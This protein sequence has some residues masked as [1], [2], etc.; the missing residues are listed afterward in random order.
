M[1]DYLFEQARGTL[2][3]DDITR[4]TVAVNITNS[5]NQYLDKCRELTSAHILACAQEAWRMNVDRAVRVER[6]LAYCKRGDDR[7]VVGAFAI[8]KAPDEKG[9]QMG[10]WQPSADGDRMIFLGYPATDRRDYEMKLLPPLPHG[11]R[12]PVKYYD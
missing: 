12:N 10:R 2:K 11:A 4:P 3:P 7:L 6:V 9:R 1:L 5:L 8:D